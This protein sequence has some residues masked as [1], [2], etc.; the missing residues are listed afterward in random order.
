MFILTLLSLLAIHQLN[1]SISVKTEKELS[2][3]DALLLYAVLVKKFGER[4][5]P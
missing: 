5:K 4:M 3:I 2:K 1:G